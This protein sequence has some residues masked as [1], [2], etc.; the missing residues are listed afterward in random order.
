MLSIIVSSVSPQLLAS[1]KINLAETVGVPYE[2][3]SYDNADGS[4]G[5][6]AVYNRGIK[7]AKYDIL[8]FMHEDIIIKTT[9]W[10]QVVTDIF[11]NNPQI[12]L[13]G[14]AGSSYKPLTPSGWLGQGTDSACINLIQHFKHTGKA[15]VHDYERPDGIEL[16]RVATVDGVWFCTPKSVAQE[17]LFD[18]DTFKA[19]HAYD[20]DFS[21]SVGQ[22]YEVVV[23]Y[24]VLMEHLSEGSYDAQWMQETLKLHDKWRK[25][26]PV[27]IKGYSLK[28]IIKI[29]FLSF[30]HF[31]N[32]L[33]SFGMPLSIAT[34]T[35]WKKGSF[36]RLSPKLFY[37]IQM[38]LLKQ[39]K[40]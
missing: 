34:K 37:K 40:S 21:L 39:K 20:L 22:K 29:E 38:Y 1:L 8:C 12:G 25:I 18:E 14:V 36:F 30:Q 24:D 32:Q 5:I 4:S 10:G 13:V 3:L 11:K 19:F 15:A 28:K 17:F 16:P 35:L 27:N 9:N 6:C 23:T 7:E 2:L 26:L 33:K 31:V